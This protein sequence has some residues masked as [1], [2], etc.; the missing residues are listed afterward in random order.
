M[1][2]HILGSQIFDYWHDPD[3]LMVE[4]FTD[5]D[6]FDNT[7]EPGWA[8]LTA[9]GLSQWGPPITRKFLGTN[10]SPRLIRDV[11]TALRDDNEVDLSRLV[12]MFKG[13][14]Q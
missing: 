2:R 14:N 13:M 4:H 1:G 8:P 3:K 5:G 6:L 11:V 10:P 9:S 12:G 7:I